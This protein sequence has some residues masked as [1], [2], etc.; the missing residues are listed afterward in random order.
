MTARKDDI[1][2]NRTPHYVSRET[3]AAELEISPATWDEMVQHGLL[4]APVMVGIAG[5]TPRWRWEDV[6]RKL[7]AQAECQEA[8]PFFRGLAGGQA[9]DR[10]RVAP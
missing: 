3:G 6:D 7:K 1:K 2:L 10:K 8:E 9:K 4:P 5:I